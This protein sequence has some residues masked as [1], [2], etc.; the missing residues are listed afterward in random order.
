MKRYTIL[1]S[2]AAIAF[3][4]AVSPALAE[5]YSYS[6]IVMAD[7]SMRT[8]KLIGLPVVNEQGQK[9][10]TIVDVLVTDKAAEPLVI[11]SVGDFA[12]GGS[13]MV[14][15]PLSHITVEKTQ[16]MMPGDTKQILASMPAYKFNPLNG[17]G[18]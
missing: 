1:A 5:S 7:H 4:F 3:A 14:A 16:I 8:S 17:G 6:E 11:L 10:G 13:K 18:G 15:A 2:T 12:G 9:V